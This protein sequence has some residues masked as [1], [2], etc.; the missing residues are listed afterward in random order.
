MKKPKQFYVYIIRDPRPGKSKAP[1][2]VG[3]GQGKR[4]FRHLFPC[5][6]AGKTL[7]RIIA[8]WK[9]MRLEPIV[10]FAKQFGDDENAAFAYETKLIAKYGRRDLGTGTLCNLT[11]GGEGTSGWVPS[12]KFRKALSARLLKLHELRPDWRWSIT[13]GWHKWWDG[14]PDVRAAYIKRA[15]DYNKTPKAK[16]H[17]KKILAELNADTEYCAAR[18]A[19]TKNWNTD[20]VLVAA[21]RKR[22]RKQN[23]NKKFQKHAQRKRRIWID[24]PETRAAMRENYANGGGEA[25]LAG[26]KKHFA[27]SK[28]R[29]KYGDRMRQRMRS[30]K[31]TAR[32][33]AGQK[34]FLE[35]PKNRARYVKIMKDRNRDP[36]Y[37]AKCKA[38]LRKARKANPHFDDKRIAALRRACAAK[39]G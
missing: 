17:L 21:K 16:A 23:K 6:Y 37:Q 27:N 36:A 24:K 9:A 19:W 26:V 5:I 11:E 20:P 15:K 38:G 7:G 1:I 4:A 39:R 29:K 25:L 12:K 8:K 13:K 30:P 3:K 28:N 10:Q 2:Y 34:R 31:Y 18:T 33:K 14:N 22:L 32:I 35:D